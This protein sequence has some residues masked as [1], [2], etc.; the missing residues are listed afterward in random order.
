M[1]QGIAKIFKRERRDFE[2]FQ[3][4]ITSYSSLECKIC[5]SAVFAENWLFENMSLE[6]FQKIS[7]NFHRTRW[8]VF[9]GWG[10]PLENENFPVMFRRTRE[11]GCLTGVATNGYHLTEERCRQFLEEGLEFI[12]ISLE[13][14]PRL[15][16]GRLRLDSDLDLILSQIENLIRLRNGR[17]RKRPVVKLSFLMTRLNMGFL[18]QAIPAAAQ[19]G[20]DG[21][22]FRNLDYLPED[23]WNILR[24]FYHESPTASFEETLEE[25]QRL[26]KQMKISVQAY[27]LKA[28][29][30]PVCEANPPKNIFFS[31]DGSVCPCMYLRLP[32]KGDIPRIFLN[33]AYSVPQTFFGN[34]NENDLSPIWD[35]EAYAAFRKVFEDRIKA[36]RHMG[37]VFDAL[38]ARSSLPP[39]T[40]EP[41]PP[42]AEACRTCYKA[43]GI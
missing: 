39:E 9:Q 8:V 1:F 5:P 13:E 2:V 30:V 34:I 21:V 32:K 23:R 33:K 26:G 19:L 43:Y 36:Q 20:L 40:L 38:S 22:I 41:P 6:T 12:N 15:E 14:I 28:E 17:G 3:I 11:A 31:V 42:L 29:E 35:R 27:P 7:A 16:N 24:T 10:D 18:P 37:S 25:I 4:E